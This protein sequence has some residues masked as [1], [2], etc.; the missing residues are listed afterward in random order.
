[1]VFE[2]TNEDNF[3][4]FLCF[5]VTKYP[6]AGR[7]EKGQTLAHKIAECGYEKVCKLIAS[8]NKDVSK[9]QDNFGETFLHICAEKKLDSVCITALEA[10]P[11]LAEIQ[12]NAGDTFIHKSALAGNENVCVKAVQV[13][14]SLIMKK[15][16]LAR[17]F[18]H[19]M[20][21]KLSMIK[22]VDIYNQAQK[23]NK[24]KEE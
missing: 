12:N 22:C 21:D 10:N 1:M 11:N 24:G 2:Y 6:F 19:C 13:R 4:N 18:L 17:T 9:I 5:Y 8:C 20:R 14:P 15:N 16:M 3:E 23:A 7:N